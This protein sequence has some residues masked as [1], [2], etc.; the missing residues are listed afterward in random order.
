MKRSQ[1]P[2]II[3]FEIKFLEINEY[4]L[5]RRKLKGR[6]YRTSPYHND[7]VALLEPEFIGSRS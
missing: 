4:A 7:A 1:L 3:Y 6:G 5:L 2:L